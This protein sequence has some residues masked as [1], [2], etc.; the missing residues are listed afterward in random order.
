MTDDVI[1]GRGVVIPAAELTLRASRASGPGGQGVNTT[2]SRV[3][4]RWDVG[5]S[6]AL[7]EPQR[8]RVLTRLSS[9]LTADG[10]LVLHAEEQRSQLRN[11]QAVVQRLRELVAEALVPE[12]PRRATRPTG[13]SVR[14]RL[15]DKRARG[16]VERLRRPPED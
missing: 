11:R 16:E 1:I 5:A 10:V 15:D 2:S 7:T 14:R 12:R 13:G 6:T 3:E 9:R 8:A 4:L